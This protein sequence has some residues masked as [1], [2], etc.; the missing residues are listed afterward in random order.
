MN[1]NKCEFKDVFVYRIITLDR[2]GNAGLIEKKFNE[3]GL[4][5]WE[6]VSINN[7]LAYFK[8]KHNEIV[9]S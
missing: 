6:L 5:G 1:T 8:R 4:E 3:L 9:L 7:N 2:I